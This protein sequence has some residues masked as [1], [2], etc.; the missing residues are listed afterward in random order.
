M[1]HA[2][3]A[4]VATAVALAA[5]PR[6]SGAQPSPP[7]SAARVDV[8]DAGPGESGRLLTAALVAPHTTRVFAGEQ[9]ALPRDTAFSTSVIVLGGTATV[10]SQVAGDVIVVGGDLFLH[11]G[12]AIAGRAVAIGGCVYNSTL[13]TVRGARICFRESTFDVVRRADGSLTLAYDDLGSGGPPWLALPGFYGFRTPGY[14]RVNGLSFAWG[15]TIAI[16]MGRL[17]IEP[18]A[19]Y[20]SDLGKVDPSIELR[21][22]VGAGTRALVSA[23]RGT[24]TNDGWIRSDLVNAIGVIAFGTDTRNYYRA[25][26]LEARLA[27]GFDASAG[28]V[29]LFAGARTED[30]RSVGPDSTSTSAPFSFFGR[31]DREQ[32]MLRPNPQ[33]TSGRINSALLGA[34]GDFERDDVSA[35]TVLV[36]ELPFDAP[37]G[38]FMQATLD[39]STSFRAFRRHTVTAG[40]HAVLTRGDPTPRQRYSYLRGPGTLPTENL[41]DRGGDELLF[42]DGLYMVPIDRVRLPLLGS[43][44]I[45]LRYAAGSVGVRELPRFTQNVGVRLAVSLARVDV[46][47]NPA[48]GATNVGVGVAVLR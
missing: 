24:Y 40:A 31:R 46:L 13:A 2:R 7:P 23:G 47:V 27:R 39:A 35:N 34:T 30:A 20:R 38:R 42:V 44:A 25:D 6:G 22:P 29:D 1:R 8:I 16:G 15:P 18:R 19:T 45:G 11:P 9:V 12:A 37:S 33:G 3:A 17:E 10:A 14:D 32:G 4:A 21:A 43:P 36:V 28:T 48:T 26:R 5:F 41:F